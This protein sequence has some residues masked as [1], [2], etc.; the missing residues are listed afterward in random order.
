MIHLL[1]FPRSASTWLWLLIEKYSGRIGANPD[2]KPLS[3]ANKFGIGEPSDASQPVS[4]LKAHFIN[5]LNGVNPA[6][7]QLILLHR[8]P[9]EVCL[10]YYG[11][12]HRVP[13][14]AIVDPLNAG[15]VNGDLRWRFK[16]HRENVRYYE[17]WEGTKHRVE[18]DLLMADPMVVMRDL[19]PIIGKDARRARA[20]S[21]TVQ[22]CRQMMLNVK[23]EPGRGNVY[24]EGHN[25]TFWRD[26][27]NDKA[28]AALS[29][30]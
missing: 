23:K 5:E 16:A 18:Y 7:H 30:L 27:L 13:A 9:L 15:Q 6:S 24:T 28:K 29:A 26:Q 10:S 20:L 19:E 11:A 14:K 12:D 17:R 4:L 1:A 8:H 3:L 22:P 2:R 21:E 25:P